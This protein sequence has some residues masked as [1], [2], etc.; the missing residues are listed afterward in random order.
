MD[1]TRQRPGDRLQR[2]PPDPSHGSGNGGRPTAEPAREVYV[3]AQL[4]IGFR[5]KRLFADDHSIFWGNISVPYTQIV[6]LS[7]WV[8]NL[9][10]IVGQN[11]DYRIVLF[12]GKKRERITFTG[13]DEYTRVAYDAAVDVLLRFVGA[14]IL[15]T[16]VSRLD[17][18]EA[19]IFAGWTLSS[20]S[21]A[22]GK[23]SVSWGTP[24]RYVP[25]TGHPPKP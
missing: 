15:T 16:T 23:K 1:R 5:H 6:A 20:T 22:Q 3:D 10:N 7:Y 8:T 18:G 4:R 24:V 2:P 13:R 9:S 19:V 14:P 12:T 17:G 25:T 21:A 11:F